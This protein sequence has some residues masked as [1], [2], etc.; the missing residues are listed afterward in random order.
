MVPTQCTY[1]DGSCLQVVSFFFKGE[2][3][4]QRQMTQ[5]QA[6]RATPKMGHKGGKGTK[7]S[8]VQSVI[9]SSL[10]FSSTYTGSK[11]T[12]DQ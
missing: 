3:E 4:E 2:K 5:S 12:L 7:G 9:P 6:S 8:K 1:E 11:V 10:E